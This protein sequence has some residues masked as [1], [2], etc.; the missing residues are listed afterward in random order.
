MGNINMSTKQS[1]EFVGCDNITENLSCTNSVELDMHSLASTIYIEFIYLTLHTLGVFTYVC[2][3][4]LQLDVRYS[5]RPV[6]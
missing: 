4:F 3:C 1:M 2:V 6:Q 5:G